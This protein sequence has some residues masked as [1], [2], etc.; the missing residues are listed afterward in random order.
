[1]FKAQLDAKLLIYPKLLVFAWLLFYF[2]WSH[3]QNKQGLSYSV[4]VDYE[5]NYEKQETEIEYEKVKISVDFQAQHKFVPVYGKLNVVRSQLTNVEYI[6]VPQ[7]ENQPPRYIQLDK[8]TPEEI[9]RTF[10]QKIGSIKEVFGRN[11]KRYPTEQLRFFAAQG[12]VQMAACFG[13][14]VRELDFKSSVNNPSCVDN[15]LMSLIDIKGWLGFYAFMVANDVTSRQL[16]NLLNLAHTYRQT[17]SNKDLGRRRPQIMATLRPYAGYIGMAFGSMAS[18]MVHHVLSLPNLKQCISLASHLKVITAAPVCK[19]VITHFAGM[20]RF[21]HNFFAGVPALLGSAILSAATQNRILKP[22]AH[23]GKI[24]ATEIGKGIWAGGKIVSSTTGLS[25]LTWAQSISNIAAIRVLPQLAQFG[26][27]FGY[28]VRVVGVGH[29]GSMVVFFAWDH[30]LRPPTVKF[31]WELIDGGTW[32]W[33]GIEDYIEDLYIIGDQIHEKGWSTPLVNE[34]CTT[35]A[36]GKSERCRKTDVPLADTLKNLQ[37]SAERYRKNTVVAGLEEASAGWRMKWQK[38]LETYITGKSL[39][40]QVYKEKKEKNNTE[41]STVTLTNFIIKVWHRAIQYQP[42]IDDKIKKQVV[43]LSQALYGTTDLNLIGQFMSEEELNK[44]VPQMANEILNLRRLA[45]QEFGN[46]REHTCDIMLTKNL[47]LTCLAVRETLKTPETPYINYNHQPNLML[48]N[49]QLLRD[50]ESDNYVVKKTLRS[51]ICEQ[52]TRQKYARSDEAKMRGMSPESG[53]FAKLILPNFIKDYTS[54]TKLHKLCKEFG[55]SV[56]IPKIHTAQLGDLQ[57]LDPLRKKMLNEAPAVDTGFLDEMLSMI[58][59]Q[60]VDVAIN[61]GYLWDTD[62][63][64]YTDPLSYLMDK[65]VQLITGGTEES[66]RRWWNKYILS[67]ALDFYIS[68]IIGY[69]EMLDNKLLAKVEQTTPQVLLQRYKNPTEIA[70]KIHNPWSLIKPWTWLNK[71]SLNASLIGHIQVITQLIDRLADKY[72]KPDEIRQVTQEINQLMADHTLHMKFFGGIKNVEE[73]LNSRLLKLKDM[74][75]NPQDVEKELKR[76]GEEITKLA[77]QDSREQL[78]ERIQLLT[79]KLDELSLL[80]IDQ[81]VTEIDEISLAMHRAAS[82]EDISQFDEKEYKFYTGLQI[83][84]HL[85]GVLDE[86]NNYYYNYIHL[87]DLFAI[88]KNH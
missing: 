61:I 44:R 76:F 17:H 4:G 63:G 27:N 62:E 55:G 28:F 86:I 82:P 54:H 65:D 8:A 36:R 30:V 45:L 7:G 32:L 48:K 13:G 16:N 33:S 34:T 20:D 52:N 38:Y 49:A 77:F 73:H 70:D 25:Q 2:P 3:A 71:T 59:Q 47:P 84:S 87:Q 24:V 60:Q 14:G 6:L 74:E 56:A 80:M 23:A 40:E 26:N 46:L 51:M 19:E 1:M 29:I 9:H 53:L 75:M 50:L 79:D 83:I 66:A 67:H 18:E 21:W 39:I 85:D 12:I 81:K 72:E 35:V 10:E 57:D 78:T 41:I 22:G 69:N 43:K 15:F 42:Y 31:Y 11:L 37:K 58:S 88:E 64:L 5:L 68:V